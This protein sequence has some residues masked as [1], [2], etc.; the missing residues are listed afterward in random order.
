MTQ[1]I[2]PADPESTDPVAESEAKVN[3][4]YITKVV[5]DVV[6]GQLEDANC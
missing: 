3:E 6:Y 5:V 1:P 2:A 4:F